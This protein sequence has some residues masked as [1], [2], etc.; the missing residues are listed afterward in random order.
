MVL[1]IFFFHSRGPAQRAGPTTQKEQF[2]DNTEQKIPSPFP[3]P[4]GSADQ[5]AQASAQTVQPAAA[6][7]SQNAG[8]P[9]AQPPQSIPLYTLT[10][11]GDYFNGG[12]FA[13]DVSAYQGYASRKTGYSNLDSIQ[14]L[15][16][17]LYALGAISSLGKTTMAH[18]MADQ[19]AATGADVLYVS[20]EQNRFEL[21]SKSMARGFFKRN[22]EEAAQTNHPSAYPT[23]SAIDLRRGAA[24][25]FP[26]EMAEQQDIYAKTVGNRMVIMDGGFSISV[27]DIVNVVFT[28]VSKGIKPIVFV[29]YLQIISPSLIGGRIPDSK[30]SIDHIVHTLKA[31]QSQLN[32]TI[33]AISS[34]NRANYLVPVDF[35]SYK[36]SGGIEYTADVVWGLQLSVLHDPE[37]EKEKKI[38][39]QREM[40]AEAK[41][42]IPR[43]VELVCLKNRY[44]LSS[45]TVHF[46]YY[47]A[48]DTFIP[49][50]I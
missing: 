33:I 35:E 19:L 1:I 24:S 12:L 13:K 16:P 30:T 45:Y 43:A 32:L 4:A 36:E 50:I 46:D 7:Q 15:Y 39:K 37:F 26:K 47:P 29:D 14:P 11:A 34:I 42:D 31:L 10:G 20:L 40:I 44:G 27:E 8:Q 9:A 18:Q 21:F 38:S 25:A 48:N 6:A 49:C 3:T 41:A 17:G 28:A 23:P 5:T 22:R 2:M